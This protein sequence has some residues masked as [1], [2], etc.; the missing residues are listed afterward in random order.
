MCVVR[1]LIK[2]AGGGKLTQGFFSTFNMGEGELK[3]FDP[4]VPVG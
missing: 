3:L 1:E 4:P 2:I